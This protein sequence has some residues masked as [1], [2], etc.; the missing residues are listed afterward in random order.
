MAGVRRPGPVMARGPDRAVTR[1]FR[2][3]RALTVRTVA[4]RSICAPPG[5]QPGRPVAAKAATC[6]HVPVID[7]RSRTALE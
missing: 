7:V 5:R 3:R 4:L 1:P 2:Q 6:C